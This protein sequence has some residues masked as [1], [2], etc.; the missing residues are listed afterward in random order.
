MWGIP[1]GGHNANKKTEPGHSTLNSPMTP[2]TLR[3][4]QGSA[5]R[6]TGASQAQCV[7]RALTC[8]LRKCE[9]PIHHCDVLAQ[10]PVDDKPKHPHHAVGDDRHANIARR[11]SCSPDGDVTKP[12]IKPQRRPLLPHLHQDW[13]ARES[14]AKPGRKQEHRNWRRAPLPSGQRLQDPKK[15]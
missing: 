3:V 6:S 7:Q 2:A 1:L 15:G 13:Q 12:R 10:E 8:N 9:I 11:G 5:P 4:L 14:G